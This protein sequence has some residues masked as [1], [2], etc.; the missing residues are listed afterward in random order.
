M[1]NVTQNLFD[2]FATRSLSASIPENTRFDSIELNF[3]Q[4]LNIAVP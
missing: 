1:R 2:G 4:P 3:N